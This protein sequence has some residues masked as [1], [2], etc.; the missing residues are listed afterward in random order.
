MY[1]LGLSGVRSWVAILRVVVCLSSL[2]VGGPAL[3][4]TGA[5]AWPLGFGSR[6]Y[7]SCPRSAVE[8]YVMAYEHTPKYSVIM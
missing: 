8:I 6:V 4:P 5:W 2:C 3:G 1:G 7:V